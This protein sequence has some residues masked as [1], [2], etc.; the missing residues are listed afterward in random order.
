[1]EGPVIHCNTMPKTTKRNQQPEDGLEMISYR[2]FASTIKKLKAEAVEWAK[3]NGISPKQ[4][5][6]AYMRHLIASHQGR[7]KR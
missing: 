1:M 5:Y 7:S 4:A 6:S 2:E 3:G